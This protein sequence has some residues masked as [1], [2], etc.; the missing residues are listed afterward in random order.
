MERRFEY[1]LPERVFLLREELEVFVGQLHWRQGLQFQVGP[2]VHKV[3]QV[4]KGVQAEAV[5]SIVRKMCHENAD[6]RKK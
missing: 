3:G 6:L 2:A 4:H 1:Y 5:I